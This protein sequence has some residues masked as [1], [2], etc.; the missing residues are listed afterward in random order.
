MIKIKWKFGYK[1]F[2]SLE[3][4]LK[5]SKMVSIFFSKKDVSQKSFS[6]F[7]QAS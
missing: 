7:T 6:L 1:H 2:F 4:G 3:N 5:F